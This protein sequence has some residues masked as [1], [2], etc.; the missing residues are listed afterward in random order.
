MKKYLKSRISILKDLYSNPLNS[1][2]YKISQRVN[3]T[4]ATIYR[5]IYRMYEEGLIC[6]S[7]EV[8]HQNPKQRKK[9]YK[10]TPEGKRLAKLFYE[11]D[12]VYKNLSPL[13][14]YKKHL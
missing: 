12:E 4:S 3:I 1:Y 7:K 14:D 13:K 2:P 5:E 10:L 6:I 11:V 9:Y 8:R